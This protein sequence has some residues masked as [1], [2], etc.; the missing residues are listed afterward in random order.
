MGIFNFLKKRKDSQVEE[1]KYITLQLGQ[2]GGLIP[3]YEAT[4]NV[5]FERN[6]AARTCIE[7]NATYCSKAE[8]RSVLRKKDG[9]KLSDYP[10]LDKLLQFRPNPTMPAA[11]F[12]ERVAYFYF[13]YNNAFIYKEINAF[14]DIVALWSIDPSMVQFTKISTGEILLKFNVDGTEIVHPY[15]D[16]I[17]VQR[18]VTTNP[19]FGDKPSRA[20]QNVINLINL[21]YRGIENAI[22]TST[23]LRFIGEYTTKLSSADLKKKA[24][25]FTNNYLNIKDTEK[26]GIAMTDSALK[27]TPIQNAKQDR[28]N[29]AEVN[30]WNQ[31]VY[32][33]FGCPEKVIAGEATEDEMVAYY[34][35]TIEP[36]FVRVAQ[37]MTC[38]IFTEREFD[39]GN[40]IEYNDQ[41][42]AYRSMK[43][44]LEIFNAAREIGAFTLGTLGDLLGLPVPHGQREKIVTSQNYFESAKT[45]GNKGENGEN[46]DKKDEENE[47]NFDENG[48]SKKNDGK[49]IS[50]GQKDADDENK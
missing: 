12:W 48:E 37:E 50:G 46:D 35:R 9:E 14:G 18:M 38:K 43:T 4:N 13:T 31:S 3:T 44:K 30:Q 25:E 26:V 2:Y 21:N 39:F 33:F 7:T 23:F 11:V 24:K 36:F 5:G 16:I 42:L 40:R 10:R 27:L 20:I 15:S 22:L 6:E 29:Y 8:F 1:S 32:K 41:K 17:H 19:L 45:Q 34:E 47:E 28:A 49:Y